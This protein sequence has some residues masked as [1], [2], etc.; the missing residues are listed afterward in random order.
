MAVHDNKILN[1]KGTSLEM[2]LKSMKR[3]QRLEIDRYKVF[4]LNRL[5]SL[6]VLSLSV[7]LIQ[8]AID[9][10]CKK[11]ESPLLLFSHVIS[12]R[13]ELEIW[14]LSLIEDNFSEIFYKKGR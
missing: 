5:I 7:R 10:V 2:Q 3:R 4:R 9:F 12:K 14:G 1:K 8:G 6:E 13:I 11:W